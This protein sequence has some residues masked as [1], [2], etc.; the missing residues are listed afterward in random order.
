MWVESTL[1]ND[2][3]V[4]KGVKYSWKKGNLHDNAH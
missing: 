3:I 1:G 4:S 2:W